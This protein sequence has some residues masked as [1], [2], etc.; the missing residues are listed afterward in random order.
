MR[1]IGRGAARRL[2][3]WQSKHRVQPQVHRMVCSDE[4]MNKTADRRAGARIAGTH[5]SMDKALLQRRAE[6]EAWTD[7]RGPGYVAHITSAVAGAKRELRA[8]T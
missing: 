4:T 8:Q 1:S 7:P 2:R 3:I 5:G 6:Y